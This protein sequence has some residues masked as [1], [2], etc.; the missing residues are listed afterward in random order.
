MYCFK[1][2]NDCPYRNICEQKT[3]DGSCYKGCVKLHEIDLLFSNANIPR[4][5]LQPYRL[6]P[7]EEDKET[8]ESLKELK[9]NIKEA[10][11][12]GFNLYLSSEVRMN[13]KTSWAIKLLQ[14]YLHMVLYDPG[15]R[16][17]GLY[18]DTN[19]YLNE[20]KASFN[21]Y[22]L[23]KD[24]RDFEKD[25]DNADLVI[26]DHIDETRLTEWERNNIKQH[27]KKR[28]A[29]GLSNIYVGINRDYKL[30]RII[31]EDLKAY[32]QDNSTNIILFGKRGGLK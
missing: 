7:A 6:F 5:Y 24:I 27:I 28:L 29:D 22:D 19:Q 26:W 11:E 18:I 31:G 25:I 9:N 10:V 14:N 32:V 1:N 23:A 20:L 15:S 13:G 2:G 8:Y 17:R 16:K 12:E 3:S 21:D 30:S 4:K